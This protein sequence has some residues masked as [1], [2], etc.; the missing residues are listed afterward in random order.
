MHRVEKFGKFQ[1]MVSGGIFLGGRTKL[2]IHNLKKG[3]FDSSVYKTVV[4]EIYKPVLQQHGLR[5]Q[6]DGC[7]SH[8][9]K[10]TK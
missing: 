5:F 9:S 10:E 4:E 2:H 6:Q 7:S 8:T 1:V 3:T